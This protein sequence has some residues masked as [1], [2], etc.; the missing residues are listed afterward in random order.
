[1]PLMRSLFSGGASPFL[2]GGGHMRA[3]ILDHWLA[4]TGTLLRNCS[5]SL[6]AAVVEVICCRKLESSCLVFCFLLLECCAAFAFAILMLS[7]IVAYLDFFFALGFGVGAG[8]GFLVSYSSG[9][10]DVIGRVN[11][12]W[13]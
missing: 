5:L 2:A 10:G 13:T 3:V 1:M 6:M 9:G 7:L 4:G 11:F 8:V 12:R